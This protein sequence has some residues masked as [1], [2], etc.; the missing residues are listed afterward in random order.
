MSAFYIE[1]E[2]LTEAERAAARLAVL[3]S[4]FRP[5]WPLLIPLFVGWMRQQFDSEGAFASGHWAPLSP[6][7]AAYKAQHYPG[8]G[9]LIAEGDLRRA[10]SNPTRVMLPLELT[11]TIEDPKVAFHQ[12]GTANMPARPLLWTTFEP[13]QVAA[14]LAGWADIVAEDALRRSGFGR[15]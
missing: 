15:I 14:E 9:I 5:W 4:D 10:A 13:P 12:E 11:L 8:R 3:L 1:V 6:N 2:G 7:Y